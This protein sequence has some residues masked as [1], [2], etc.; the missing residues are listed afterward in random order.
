ML[1]I[2]CGK[3]IQKL[4]S[5][6]MSATEYFNGTSESDWM[7]SATGRTSTTGRRHDYI[8]GADGQNRS[9]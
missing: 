5:G 1:A 9:L 3:R 2:G 6:G 8:N 7:D 4:K